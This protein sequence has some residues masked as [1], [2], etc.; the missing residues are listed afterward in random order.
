MRCVPPVVRHW[1]RPV[2]PSKRASRRGSAFTVTVFD[3]PGP[4]ATRSKP[5]SRVRHSPAA[6]VR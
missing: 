1:P 2:L 4:S 5:S 6:S 3:S